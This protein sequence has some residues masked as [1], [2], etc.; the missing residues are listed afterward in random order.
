MKRQN[1]HSGIAIAL[2][3]PRTFC[4]QPG[5]WYDPLCHLLGISYRHYYRVGHAAVVL[6]N[7]QDGRCLYFD[8]GRYIA[9]MYCGRVRSAKTDHRLKIKTT[10][11]VS[12][13]PL[14]LLN[15]NDILMELRGNTDCHGE[16]PMCGSYCS[17]NFHSALE[18]AQKMQQ[19]SPLPYGPFIWNGTNCSRFVRTVILAGKPGLIHRVKL[20]FLLPVTPR[21]TDNINSLQHPIVLPE[22]GGKKL[23]GPPTVKNKKMLKKTL[24]QPTKFAGIPD[25]AQWLSGEGSGSWFYIQSIEEGYLILRYDTEGQLECSGIFEL[26]GEVEF[27][28]DAEF[29]FAHMSHC[30]KVS[31]QQSGKIY[32]FIRKE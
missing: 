14:K 32:E 27:T 26:N 22:V 17:V 30:Q 16:G 18:C 20:N 8:F 7:G 2:A 9:P 31:I 24:P 4:K 23:F 11:K 29:N 21:P 25:E 12:Y 28:I 5:G 13:N 15:Y 6:V 1:K 19:K 3:W 10:A